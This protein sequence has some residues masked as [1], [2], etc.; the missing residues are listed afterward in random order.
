[1]SKYSENNKKL[2]KILEELFYVNQF[3]FHI[4]VILILIIINYYINSNNKYIIDNSNILFFTLVIIF[5]IAIIIDYK[6]WKNKNKTLIFGFI[7]TFLSLYIYQQ[8]IN[9]KTYISTFNNIKELFINNNNSNDDSNHNLN[10]NNLD[11]EELKK[12]QR[13]KQLKF[14]N[15]TIKDEHIY[16][17]LPDEIAN[18]L[19]KD[20]NNQKN[21]PEP[22]RKGGEFNKI[23]ESDL[24]HLPKVDSINPKW[25]R[26]DDA[27]N[28]ALKEHK[29][30]N[31][32]KQISLEENNLI[33]IKSDIENNDK[34]FKDVEWDLNRYYPDCSKKELEN[35]NNIPDKTIQYCSNLPKI[36]EENL[37]LISN[38]KVEQIKNRN[39]YINAFNTQYDIGGNGIINN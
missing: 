21:I 22:F 28:I 15:E 33:H 6:V 26:I 30:M 16:D 38:N 27:I 20:S 13:E 1:M 35:N 39:K 36:E 7:I 14:L 3:M 29:E 23:K 11:I 12:I 24:Q 2:T 9:S 34:R 17:Y 10:N 8:S 25:D 19:I 31:S 18:D 32:I 4:L 37:N 5:M